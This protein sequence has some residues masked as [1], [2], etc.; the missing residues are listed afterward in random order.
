MTLKSVDDTAGIMNHESIEQVVTALVGSTIIKHS[1]HLP[2]QGRQ[3][4]DVPSINPSSLAPIPAAESATFTLQTPTYNKAELIPNKVQASVKVSN[5]YMDDAISGWWP[6]LRDTL[7]DVLIES[8]EN[9]AFNNLASTVTTI[10]AAGAAPT[11]AE[12]AST[13]ASLAMFGHRNAAWYVNPAFY[14]ENMLPVLPAGSCCNAP[15]DALGSFAGYPVYAMSTMDAGGSGSVV[16]YFGDLKKSL[17]TCLDGVKVRVAP[18]PH[19]E[20]DETLILVSAR[21]AGVQIPNSPLHA[22][23]LP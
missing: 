12:L 16:G 2:G 23:K 6:S 15:E 20:T 19:A 3:K 22:I 4:I 13:M 18:E 8:M 17:A 21:F 5:E 1:F 9:L 10:T 11:Y 7:T 14:V